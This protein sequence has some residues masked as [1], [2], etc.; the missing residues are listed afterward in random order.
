MLAPNLSSSP[1][2]LYKDDRNL[3]SLRALLFCQVSL[4]LANHF[5]S[6]GTGVEESLTNSEI[7]VSWGGG[8][9]K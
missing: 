8:W 2:D 5:K 6:Y 7:N 4:K 3:M 9:W 1:I